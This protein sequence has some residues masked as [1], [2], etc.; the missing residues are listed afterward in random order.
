MNILP[1]SDESIRDE[2]LEV[3]GKKYN[4]E[5][6]AL[7]LE[8]GHSDLLIAYVQGGDT[9]EDLVRAQRVVRDDNAEYND[10]YF[11]IIIREDIEAE[12]L[13][14]CSGIEPPMRVLYPSNVFFYDNIFDGT[15]NYAD[16]KQWIAD[17]NPWRFDATIILSLDEIA[18]GETYANKVFE[19]LE[20]A[21]FCGYIH[22]VVLQSEDFAKLTRTNLNDI[23]KQYDSQTTLFTKSIN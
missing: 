5:F 17:G 9:D 2:I 18:E 23:L 12:I 19:K 11:G 15:K 7:A 22:V 3:I 10:T 8:R 4:T 6:V 14:V 20:K 21:D 13:A 1:Q 16:F